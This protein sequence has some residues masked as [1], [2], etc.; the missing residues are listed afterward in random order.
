M[1]EYDKK[2]YEY[3][4][5]GAIRSARIVLPIM[6]T[7]FAINSV[8]DFGC[9]QGAWLKVWQELGVNEVV[10]LDGAYV[11]RGAL[12]IDVNDFR[13]SELSHAVV[14]AHTYDLAQ[15]LEVAEHLPESSAVSFVESLTRHARIILFSAAPPGQGGEN[16]INEQP[17]EYWRGLFGQFGYVPLDIIRPR[18]R[19]NRAVEPWYRFNTFV[20]VDRNMLVEMPAH[21]RRAVIDSS[22]RILDISPLTYRIRK[23]LVGVLTPGIMTAVAKA[24]KF[25][26]TALRSKV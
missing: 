13:P 2:F 16:H 5:K 22:S 15:S 14:L 19:G 6:K 8:V 26:V 25:L 10:G 11:D 24:K 21:L 7:S 18:V 17:Y 1:H 4:N 20:Y 3:I 9:G 23:K 12:L